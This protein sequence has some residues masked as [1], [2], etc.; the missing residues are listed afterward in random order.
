MQCFFLYTYIKHVDYTYNQV[1][2]R[3]FLNA[4]SIYFRVVHTRVL[5]NVKNTHTH[6]LFPYKSRRAPPTDC[7]HGRAGVP[8]PVGDDKKASP[9]PPYRLLLWLFLSWQLSYHRVHMWCG[10]WY[11][12]VVISRPSRSIHVRSKNRNAWRVDYLST[13]TLCMYVARYLLYSK[14]LK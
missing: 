1:L 10:W 8:P 2:L 7:V 6:F 11:C 14:W 9:P 3:P 13:V 12:F 4:R 5:C